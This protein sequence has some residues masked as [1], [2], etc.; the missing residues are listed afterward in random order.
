MLY[1][2]PLGKPIAIT[3]VATF[4]IS[5]FLFLSADV[6]EAQLEEPPSPQRPYSSFKHA[7]MIFYSTG[8]VS[9]IMFDDELESMEEYAERFKEMGY[10]T[11]LLDNHP[12]RGEIIEATS[13][14]KYKFDMEENRVRLKTPE[15]LLPEEL[16]VVVTNKSTKFGE[17][18]YRSFITLDPTLGYWIDVY[19]K[20]SYVVEVK[21][22][23][24]KKEISVKS[25]GEPGTTGTCSIQLSS[26]LIAPSDIRVYLDSQPWKFELWKNPLGIIPSPAKEFYIVTVE[27]TNSEHILSFKSIPIAWY[28]SPL[29]L[30]LIAIALLGALGA[31]Y[32]L[33][34]RRST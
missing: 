2:L 28:T 12:M 10:I 8:E 1:L 7:L 22:H 15:E 26:K 14:W 21:V 11:V 18:I 30:A 3:L 34:L 23:L 4:L 29:N 27:Y 6:V 32:W 16:D 19:M 5:S 17:N 24:K 33:R 9:S 13:L 25:I 31:V 20:G